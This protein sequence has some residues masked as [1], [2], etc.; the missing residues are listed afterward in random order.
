MV[1]RKRVAFQSLHFTNWH[2]W[3]RNPKEFF[4]D[5]Q[6]ETYSFIH[7]GI[8]GW[9]PRDTWSLDSY[10]SDIL[11]GLLDCLNDSKPGVGYTFL[12]KAAKKLGK[13]VGY[14]FDYDNETTTLAHTMF[15]QELTEISKDLRKYRDMQWSYKYTPDE[16]RQIIN[17]A[18]KAIKRIASI[19][20]E[21]WS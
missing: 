11:P 9:A 3:L 20:P 16:E 17:K 15:A 6:R 21:L 12:Q 7:R 10:L 2:Y 19:F 13:S 1:R 18:E 5:V 4:K 14:G 8:F